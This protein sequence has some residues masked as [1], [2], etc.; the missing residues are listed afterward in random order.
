M[1]HPLRRV[2]SEGTN[3]HGLHTET[4]EC[5]HTIRRKKDIIGYTNACRRRCRLCPPITGEKANGNAADQ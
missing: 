2:V 1:L 5:G 4:L 3:E